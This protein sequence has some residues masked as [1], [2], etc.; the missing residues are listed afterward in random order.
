M[1][2]E[3]NDRAVLLWVMKTF[4]TSVGLENV[5]GGP[6]EVMGGKKK[7]AFDNINA[8]IGAPLGTKTRTLIL[9]K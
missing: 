5:V 2:T 3:D 4:Q 8:L 1:T 6:A 9:L 7:L